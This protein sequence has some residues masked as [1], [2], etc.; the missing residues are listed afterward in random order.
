MKELSSDGYLSARLIIS[1]A[2]MQKFGG[3]RKGRSGF[4]IVKVGFPIL[5]S[6]LCVGIGWN[7]T[8]RRRCQEGQD[9]RIQLL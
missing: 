7:E 8:E 1:A 5:N 4:M 2:T 3:S 6:S 9:A